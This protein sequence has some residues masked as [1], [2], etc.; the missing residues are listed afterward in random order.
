MT[1]LAAAR[2]CSLL[3]DQ[4]QHCDAGAVRKRCHA[5]RSA[6]QAGRCKALPMTR[7]LTCNRLLV[8]QCKAL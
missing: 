1:L 2:I 5:R 7:G 6:Q 4:S 8:C 3:A